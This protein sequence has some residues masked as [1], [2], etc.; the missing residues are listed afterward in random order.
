MSS[1]IQKTDTIIKEDPEN[2]NADDRI[3]LNY[4]DQIND[5]DNIGSD[6][7]YQNFTNSEIMDISLE[8]RS[9]KYCS[10]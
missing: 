9:N 3:I 7:D 10:W 1:T 6:I 8:E 5:N 4:I 2:L